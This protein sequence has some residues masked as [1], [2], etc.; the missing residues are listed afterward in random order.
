MEGSNTAAFVRVV[1]ILTGDV[2][3]VSLVM[4]KCEIV[5]GCHESDIWVTLNSRQSDVAVVCNI[6]EDILGHASTRRCLTVQRSETCHSVSEC[7][8]ACTRF[9][10]MRCFLFHS[11]PSAFRL[12]LCGDRDGFGAVFSRPPEVSLPWPSFFAFSLC[13]FLGVSC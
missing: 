9:V 3:V 13:R 1:H 2:I 8:S 5:E 12:V 7:F 6:S 10:N 4:N 11:G